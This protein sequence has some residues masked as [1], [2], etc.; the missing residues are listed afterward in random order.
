MME[1]AKDN[2]V[3]EAK[4]SESLCDS[5]LGTQLR[6]TLLTLP[7]IVSEEWQLPSCPH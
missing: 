4:P 7:A 3:R 5:L 1:G 2:D 6:W